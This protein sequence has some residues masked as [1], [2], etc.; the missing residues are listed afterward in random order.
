D[1]FDI[2]DDFLAESAG[3]RAALLSSIGRDANAVAVVSATIASFLP[4]PFVGNLGETALFALGE[5][6]ANSTATAMALGVIPGGK[7]AAWAAQSKRGSLIGK[8]GSSAW[9]AAKHY[10]TK[11]TGVLAR[12]TG[13]LAKRARDFL[14][15]K[16]G[17]ACGCFTAGT[18]VWTAT[19]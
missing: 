7:L 9:G 2:V 11:A 4:F 14:R 1:P 17:S 10:A 5:Q 15:R 6:G 8:V 18:L 3:S 12:I 19:G 13:G 16:P